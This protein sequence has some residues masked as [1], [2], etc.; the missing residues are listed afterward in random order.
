MNYKRRELKTNLPKK[1]PDF[2]AR[3]MVIWLT[4]NLLLHLQWKFFSL[5]L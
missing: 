4:V 1:I 2:K 3:D 5:L